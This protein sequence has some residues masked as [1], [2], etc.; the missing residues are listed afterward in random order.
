ML[1]RAR[2]PSPLGGFVSMSFF[3]DFPVLV[4]FIFISDLV[5]YLI[6]EVKEILT[7]RPPEYRKRVKEIRGRIN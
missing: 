6:K 1:I 5:V 4:S 2:F 3:Y 7:P